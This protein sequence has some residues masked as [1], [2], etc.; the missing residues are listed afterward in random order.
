MKITLE[1]KYNTCLALN[2]E[3]EEIIEMQNKQIHDLEREN[4]RLSNQVSFLAR[5]LDKANEFIVRS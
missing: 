2:I 4:S 3:L 5:E 1:D